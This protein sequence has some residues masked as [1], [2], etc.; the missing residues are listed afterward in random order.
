M[1]E[2]AKVTLENEMDLILAH[3]RSMKLGELVGLSLP[4]QTTFATAVSEISRSTIE[5]GKSGHLILSVDTNKRDKYIVAS[6][7]NDQ[8]GDANAGTGLEYAKK[9]VNKYQVS[10]DGTK[11][12]IELFY[13]FSPPFKVDTGKIDEWRALYRNEPPVSPYEELKRKNEQ[14]QDLSER[15]KK[16]EGQYKSLT[17][18]LPLMIF[19][20]D[21]D[22]QLLFANEWLYRY[23]GQKMESLNKDRWK[24]IVYPDDYDAF[25]ILFNSD[26]ARGASALKAQAR[27]KN[28]SGEYLWHQISLNSFNNEQG[29]YLYWIG[30]IVDIHAQKVYEETLS[31]NIEL[32]QTQQQLRENQQKLETYVE[33]L[34]RSNRELQQFAF[35]AS[36][37]LQEPLR[38]LLF[39]SDY[40]L[41]IYRDSFDKK[42]IESLLSMQSATNR[43]RN[44]IQD[45]LSFSQIT[46]EQIK[47]QNVDLNEVVV[48]VLQ[49][50]EVVVAEKAATINIQEF[51]EGIPGDKR[52]MLQ[53]FQ[54]I[55]GNSLKYTTPTQSPDIDVTWQ[56][57]EH[58]IE[59]AFKDNGIGFDP[60][61]LPIIFTL[62]QRLHT[63][64]K[65]QGT[66]LGLAIC[67][68]IVEAH[69]GKIWATSEEGMGSIFYVALPVNQ[70]IN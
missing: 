53:L 67:N 32:K 9:L 43:M 40:L 58:F 8:L 27:L 61:Y 49:D 63:Q 54:N 65:Y 51:P 56:R 70:L 57:S 34:N 5:N 33:E 29:E 13:Q 26:I 52:M 21:I 50:M 31:D 55:I 60:V 17:N 44:L 36:H 7:T 24:S 15:I 45:L 38:K 35:V 28:Q 66:G 47:L 11:M 23:T 30:F 18:A 16:S 39:Y 68:K 19:S 4:A 25:S 59:I 2:L 22:G 46:R 41:S 14:L 48:E 10:R 37:D 62:F 12:I 20:L 42:A 1:H 6:L 3:K 64:E 69:K